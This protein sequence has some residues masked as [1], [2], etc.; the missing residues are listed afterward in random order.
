MELK[1]YKP[2]KYQRTSYNWVMDKPFC[3]LFLD[4]GLGK[5]VIT[6]TAICDLFLKEEI[7]R[8]L[9]VAPLRVANTVWEQEA[10][11]W[12]HTSWLKFSRVT[13]SEVDRE[14]ALCKEAHI[15]VINREN[16]KWLCDLFQHDLPFDMLVVDEL[17]SFKSHDSQRFLSIKK[18]RQSFKRIV[19]LTGTPTGNSYMGLWAEMYVLDGG[20]RLYPFITRFRETYFYQERRG[21]SEHAVQYILRP[22]AQERINDRIS[23]I[24]LAMKTEDYL[25]LPEFNVI[26]EIITLSPQVMADYRTFEKDRILTLLD[27]SIEAENKAALT[28]KLLQYANGAVYSDDGLS[29]I[30]EYMTTHNQKIE[31]LLMLIEKANGEP[32]LVGYNYK[33]DLERIQRALKKEFPKLRVATL[34]NDDVIDKWNSKQIDVLLAHPM[35]AGHGLNLQFGG[36][37]VIWFGLPWSLEYYQQF[38]KR[39][40]RNGITY[41][42]TC[43]RI[44]T[45]NTYEDVVKA[46]LQ[47]NSDRQ[48]ALLD[49]LIKFNII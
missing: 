39:L 33:H 6:L 48:Q 36:N 40:H 46:S 21:A 2:Y 1:T 9:I 31:R 24:C 32:V 5:T 45:E 27:A 35:S 16:I 30:R 13:G 3:G 44:I 22:G 15:Y 49:Y 11:K 26:D 23:D 14:L 10:K 37:I 7:K 29:S 4:M 25:D 12:E 43:Y 8:V 42:V 41:P 38:N 17:S 20:H 18:S 34:D 28:N 47:E 19:G